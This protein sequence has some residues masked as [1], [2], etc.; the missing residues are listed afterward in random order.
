MRYCIYRKYLVHVVH[1]SSTTCIHIVVH[2]RLWLA[3]NRN[4]KL[5]KRNRRNAETDDCGTTSISQY[6]HTTA[7]HIHRQRETHTHLDDID[8]PQYASTLRHLTIQS[9]C[10]RRR[11]RIFSYPAPAPTLHSQ[12]SPFTLIPSLYRTTIHVRVCATTTSMSK[13]NRNPHTHTQADKHAISHA[14]HTREIR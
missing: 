13:W 4:I 9:V 1:S 12:S 2:C 8:T 5:P 6:Y 14:L 11:C 3:T 7:K 10:R